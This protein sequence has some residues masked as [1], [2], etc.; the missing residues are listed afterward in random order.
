M[1]T[2][3][4][5]WVRGQTETDKTNTTDKAAAIAVSARCGRVS[6]R[7]KIGQKFRWDRAANVPA[8]VKEKQ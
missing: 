5:R 2:K 4:I 8:S 6:Q 3:T 7:K 1:Q